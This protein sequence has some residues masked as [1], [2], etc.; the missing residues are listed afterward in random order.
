MRKRCESSWS[1]LHMRSAMHGSENVKHIGNLQVE[2]NIFKRLTMLYQFL[3]LYCVARNL[4]GRERDL[5]IAVFSFYI[6]LQAQ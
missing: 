3:R 6:I 5:Q 4:W 1:F 2:R